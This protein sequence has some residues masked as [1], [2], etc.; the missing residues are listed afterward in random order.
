M[1]QIG[2]YI[3]Q[4]TLPDADGKIYTT[5]DFAGKKTVVYF[6]PKDNTSGCTKQACAFSDAYGEFQKLNVNIVGISKDSVKSHQNFREKYSLPFILLSD[7][8]KDV[9]QKFGV[10]KEKVLYGK[11]YMGVARSSFVFDENGKLIQ[12]YEKADPVKNASEILEYLKS[13]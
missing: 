7:P 13:L 3:P 6:Y 2:D 11:P 8:E 1:I 10:W 4:F 12:V 5:A 9:I